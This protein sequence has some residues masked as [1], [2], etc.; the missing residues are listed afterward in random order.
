M[1]KTLIITGIII[2]VIA[3]GLVFVS[4]NNSAEEKEATDENQNVSPEPALKPWEITVGVYDPAEEP[5]ALTKL[6]ES[7]LKEVGFKTTILKE[8][9][10]PDAANSEKTTLLFRSNTAEALVVVVR[11]IMSSSLYRKGLNEAIIED[12]VIGS[13]NIEDINWGSFADLAN[14]YDNPAPAEV[15]VLVVNAGAKAGSAA[16]LAEFLVAQGYTQAKAKNIE[17]A[18]IADRPALIYYDRNYKNAAKNL[19]QLLS[20]NG[21][22]EITYQPRLNQEAKIVIILGP[23]QEE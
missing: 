9:V 15:S 6:L 20:E 16:D 7:R 5:G 4:F 23:V 22:E 2:L 12:V 8:L 11:E 19:R 17:A 13:W 1:K 21:Y 3:A 14:K 10:D 18:E